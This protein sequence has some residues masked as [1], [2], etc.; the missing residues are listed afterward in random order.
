MKVV[1]A[2]SITYRPYGTES[3]I[4]NNNV[5]K[6]NFQVG[7]LTHTHNNSGVFCQK[8]YTLPVT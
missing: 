3:H 6:D 2:F 1:L 4:S 7:T 8:P 5:H